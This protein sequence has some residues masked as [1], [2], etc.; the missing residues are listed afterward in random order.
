MGFLAL[1][2]LF[3]LGLAHLVSGLAHGLG[4]AFGGRPWLGD[5]LA[6]G[7]L[8]L[9]ILGGVAAS[10]LLWRRRHLKATI[11]RYHRRRD[12]RQEAPGRNGL[13]LG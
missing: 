13:P 5:L 1:S 10:W 11:Q 7:G 12:E 8:V 6:G 9:F 4:E 3:L 2:A